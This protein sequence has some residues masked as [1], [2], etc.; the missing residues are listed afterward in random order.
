M[1]LTG[2]AVLTVLL[3]VGVLALVGLLVVRGRSRRWWL[4][5]A[6]A[7]V[8]AV[9]VALLFNPVLVDVLDL[10]PEYADPPVTVWTGVGAGVVVLTVAGLVAAPTLPRRG[11][12]LV[13]GLLALVTAASQIN[14][15]F[16]AYTTLGELFGDD[17][18]SSSPLATRGG[19][20]AES[21]PAYT[22]WTGSPTGTSSITETPIPGPVSGFVARDA[23]VYLPPI[24]NQPGAPRLPVL[25]L[26]AGQPGGPAD[27]VTSGMLQQLL[28]TFA[29]AHRG[30]A[31]V[32]VVVDPNGSELGNTMCM[33]SDVAKA[34]TYLTQDVRT[35]IVDNLYVDTNPQHWTFGGWSF[36][37][38]CAIQ[39]ATRH[40][41]L[42]GT[43]LD[44]QGEQE[45]ALGPNRAQTIQTAFGGNTA[46]FDALV[47]MTL[48]AQKRYPDTWG[49]FASG[50]EDT[51]F[52]GYLTTVSAA[53]QAAGMTVR[54]GIVP[55]A[56]H[57]WAVPT[58]QFPLAME[59]VSQRLGFSP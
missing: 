31:P 40:P 54:T 38:T 15:S 46:A 51:V 22:R 5:P 29:A 58:T 13:C 30:M 24:Y 21:T 6:V 27:W 11:L 19:A 12:A 52:T 4:V 36:G 47:P 1:K 34:D 53:A 57:S 3:V 32:T 8:V 35:W 37:G 41:D 18:V 39:M 23:Y 26:V 33:D 20:A 43:F 17:D 59:F 48:L 2:T 55:G 56:A 25:I 28:D 49:Y 44:F 16:D 42:F 7:V 50:A 10:F 9:A 45:P 14:A